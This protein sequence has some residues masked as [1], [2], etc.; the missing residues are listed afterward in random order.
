MKVLVSVFILWISIQ[1]MIAGAFYAKDRGVSIALGV[2][3]P[4]AAFRP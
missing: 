2:L 1:L 4:L 3:F